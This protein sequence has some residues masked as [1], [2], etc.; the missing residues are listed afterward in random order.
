MS[1]K[2]ISPEEA[3]RLMKEEGYTYL[4]VRSIP[5]FD[6]GHP[7]GAVN[8]P[9]MHM[10]S[11]GMDPNPD[12]LDV[13]QANFPKDSK[14]ILGCRSGGRSLKAAHQLLSAGYT[15]VVDQRAGY[16][17][18]KG[19]GEHPP[20][21]GWEPKQLPVEKDADPSRRYGELAKKAGKG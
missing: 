2:R 6:E 21:E 12:F 15:D 10:V 4:D 20:E 17:G 9:L 8:I 13:V 3:Q 18:S 1:V 5:E 7:E 19:H 11:G 16:L 14:L